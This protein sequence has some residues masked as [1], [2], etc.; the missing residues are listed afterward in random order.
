MAEPNG[1]LS[2]DDRGAIKSSIT[3]GTAVRDQHVDGTIVMNFSTADPGDNEAQHFGFGVHLTEQEKL[4]ADA[5][6][7]AQQLAAAQEAGVGTPEE[8]HEL[9][10][11]EQM[12]EEHARALAALGGAGGNGAGAHLGEGEPVAWGVDEMPRGRSF[13]NHRFVAGL[14]RLAFREQNVR[15]CAGRALGVVKAAGVGLK[16]AV[17]R[18]AAEGDARGV[19]QALVQAEQ[20][21]MG[22]EMSGE[23]VDAAERVARQ[24]ASA[25]NNDS[26]SKNGEGRAFA[27]RWRKA[28]ESVERKV[29]APMVVI[30]DGMFSGL[31]GTVTS[32]KPRIVSHFVGLVLHHPP[33]ESPLPYRYRANLFLAEPSPHVAYQVSPCATRLLIDVPNLLPSDDGVYVPLEEEEGEG[34]S[35]SHTGGVHA[36]EESKEMATEDV[37]DR[38]RAEGGESKRSEEDG[39]E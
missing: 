37:G 27:M 30:A 14:R 21:A 16:D 29:Y 12:L 17:G 19:L 26:G 35:S 25:V 18:A 34:D 23:E 9:D 6:R 38:G 22:R 11:G 8:E 10:V 33:M 4:A 7:V 15:L 36:E 13:H 20:D 3:R 28:G 5:R 39:E 32:A 1:K 24:I 2:E 31:R